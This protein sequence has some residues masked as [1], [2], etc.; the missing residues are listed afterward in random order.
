ML[1]AYHI[2]QSAIMYN[3]RTFQHYTS[4]LPFH[5]LCHCCHTFSF[6]FFCFLDGSQEASQGLNLVPWVRLPHW[7]LLQSPEDIPKTAIST[8]STYIINL[9]ILHYYFCFIQSIIFLKKY[10]LFTQL[11]IILAL[12]IPSC[13][14]KFLPGIIFLLLE[15]FL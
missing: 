6:L 15:N 14:S 4:I 8:F 13:R 11:F 10:F 2:S 7:H 1:T 12:F 3:V 5:P 9:Q